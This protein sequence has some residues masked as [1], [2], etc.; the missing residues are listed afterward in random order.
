VNVLLVT[1]NL[2]FPEQDTVLTLQLKEFF[3]LFNKDGIILLC[4]NLMRC[5]TVLQAC[6]MI[7]STDCEVPF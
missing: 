5:K 6:M 1:A 3:L 4:P 2:F 7:S